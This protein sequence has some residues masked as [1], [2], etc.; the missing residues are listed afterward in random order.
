MIENFCDDP[1]KINRIRF[2]VEL[3]DGELRLYNYFHLE[4]KTIASQYKREELTNLL[5]FLYSLF[6]VIV[7]FLL[8][9]ATFQS[10]KMKNIK[11][12][13]CINNRM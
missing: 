3:G 4:K 12:D 10:R 5:L 9:L 8:N 2:E 13:I 7:C 1:N 11:I 6:Q